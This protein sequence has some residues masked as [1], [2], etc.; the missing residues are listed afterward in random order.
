MGTKPIFIPP[1]FQ[2]NANFCITETE[3]ICRISCE[4]IS[5]GPASKTKT[6]RELARIRRILF[7][8]RWTPL[9]TDKNGQMTY[10]VRELCRLNSKLLK[11]N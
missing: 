3:E 11:D 8:H 7:N 6:V 1:R 2:R 10:E 5:P 9:S 4:S